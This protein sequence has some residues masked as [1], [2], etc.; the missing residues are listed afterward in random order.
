MASKSLHQLIRKRKCGV[1]YYGVTMLFGN[2]L[3]ASIKHLSIFSAS[4]A[5]DYCFEFK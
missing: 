5:L 1:D 3:K 2:I 4:V